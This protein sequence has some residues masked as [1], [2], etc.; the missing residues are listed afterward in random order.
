[1]NSFYEGFSFLV[2][3]QGL[4]THAYQHLPSSV[5]STDNYRASMQP[6]TLILN[7]SD[8]NILAGQMSMTVS[9]VSSRLEG[10]SPTDD[11]HKATVRM[12]VGVS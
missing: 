9:E 2:P 12:D 10:D 7:S 1:M 11:T 3:P 8:I 4:P 5:N 6:L